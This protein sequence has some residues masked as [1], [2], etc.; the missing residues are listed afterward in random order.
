MPRLNSN[1][2][3]K[4]CNVF[5]CCIRAY[6]LAPCLHNCF[7]MSTRNGKGA[8]AGVF[9]DWVPTRVPLQIL[10]WMV[11]HLVNDG[12]SAHATLP[13]QQKSTLL[14]RKPTHAYTDCEISGLQ[15]TRLYKEF[16]R[17]HS[18]MLVI[19]KNDAR[20]RIGLIATPSPPRVTKNG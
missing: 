18:A 20:L 9:L 11:M 15:P 7:R 14:P 10:C 16:P 8:Y 6:T 3:R 13:T 19:Q 17:I 2:L 1:I 4:S 5:F 12:K